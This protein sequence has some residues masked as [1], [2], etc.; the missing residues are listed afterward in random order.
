MDDP[1]SPI[2]VIGNKNY[3]SWSMRPWVLMRH[4]ELPFIE[5]H[6]MLRRPDTKARLQAISPA[7]R[8][9]CLITDGEPIWDSLAIMEWLHEAA[10]GLGMYPAEARTRALA[11]SLSAEMHSGFFAIRENL[12]MNIRRDRSLSAL[13]AELSEE[14]ERIGEIF[15]AARGPYLLG[16]FGIVDAM[17]S[18]VVMRLHSYRIPVSAGVRAYMDQ[19]MA[20]PAV[21][22]WMDAARREPDALPEIDQL[23]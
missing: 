15:G 14:L 7:A 13:P 6:V 20:T 4:F 23:D 1:A 10:P 18:P 19:V 11:R 17:Y 5:R 3:S 2:L 22:A 16:R 12:P 21:A 9:P 8:V